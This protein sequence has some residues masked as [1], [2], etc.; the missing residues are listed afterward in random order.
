MLD[1][2]RDISPAPAAAARPPKGRAVVVE[3]G[4]R[5]GFLSSP[6]RAKSDDYTNRELVE[7]CLWL[8]TDQLQVDRDTR[9]DQAVDELGFQRRSSKIKERIGNALVRAQQLVDAQGA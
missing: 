6:R 2:E 7:L 3:R 5:P 4:P 1:A 8:L 9:I